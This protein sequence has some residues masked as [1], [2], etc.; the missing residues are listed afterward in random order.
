MPTGVGEAAA[1]AHC[2]PLGRNSPAHGRATGAGEAAA[3]AWPEL[4]GDTDRRMGDHRA[5]AL[6]TRLARG[7]RMEH[8]GATG[9]S[10]G[11]RRPGSTRIGDGEA[12]GG[13][14]DSGAAGSGAR[15]GGRSRARRQR[16]GRSSGGSGERV[17]KKEKNMDKWV[18]QKVY[19]IIQMRY[20][21]ALSCHASTDSGVCLSEI[22]LVGLN[23]II[24]AQ[25][26]EFAQNR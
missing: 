7:H 17:G 18:P 9:W 23:Q 8:G 2:R 10:T 21:Q 14:G 3:P 25:W 11:G 4:A 12:G 26:N 1:P 24:S 22:V 13:N 20:V 19:K 6:P 5:H 16:C 15:G